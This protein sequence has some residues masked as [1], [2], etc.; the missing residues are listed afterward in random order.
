MVTIEQVEKL[1]Q[2]ANVSY[3][4][5]K[6]ALEHTGGNLLEAVIYL[7]NQGKV[8]PN[9]GSFQGNYSIPG[10]GYQNPN[11]PPNATIPTGYTPPSFGERFSE[12]CRRIWTWL[13]GNYVVISKEG[14]EDWRMP[15]FITLILLS[16]G[17]YFVIPLAIVGLF[18]GYRY[19]IIGADISPKV[20][21][22]FQDFQTMI[23]PNDT[24]NGNPNV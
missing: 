4:E 20:E 1:Q 14:V 22:A 12:S 6:E 7:E 23:N 11:Q 15:L 17:F 21:N 3:E 18:F 5:A 19:A 2:R 8:S 9:G 24:A 13:S 16:L 10:S